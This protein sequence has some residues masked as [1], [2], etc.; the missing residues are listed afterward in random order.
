MR[1]KFAIAANHSTRRLAKYCV[2]KGR[3]LATDNDQWPEHDLGDSVEVY[4]KLERP[5]VF[6]FAYDDYL[7]ERHI[8]CYVQSENPQQPGRMQKS[9]SWTPLICQHSRFAPPSSR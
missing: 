6:S 1:T 5:Q 3:L 9:V 2:Y 4:G 7:S 8:R